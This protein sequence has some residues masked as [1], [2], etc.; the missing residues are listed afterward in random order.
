MTI[1]HNMRLVSSGGR[2]MYIDGTTQKNF[3]RF[4]AYIKTDFTGLIHNGPI[5]HGLKKWGRMSQKDVRHYLRWGV[6]PKLD[7]TTF[8]PHPTAAISN[9]PAEIKLH[10][11]MVD[12][13][14]RKDT[15]SRVEVRQPNGV[16]IPPQYP[17]YQNHLGRDFYIVGQEILHLLVEGHVKRFFPAKFSSITLYQGFDKDVYGITY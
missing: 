8:T 10:V 9:F 17:V 4:T 7:V 1:R 6:P 5:V 16:I 15:L 14:E 2:I 12:Q 11:E 3:P 13:F